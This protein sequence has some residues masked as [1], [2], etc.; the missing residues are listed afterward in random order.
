MS[1]SKIT[2][3]E[4]KQAL[5]DSRFRETLPPD[6]TE[7]VHKFLKNPACACNLPLYRKIMRDCGEQLRSYFPSRELGNIEEEAKNMAENKFSV[8]NC[9]VHELEDKLRKL[10]VGRKQI[11]I[12]RYGDQVTVVVNELDVIY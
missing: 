11:A 1:Q 10:G 2:L 9:S 3:L 5:K 4:I 8:I 6:L 12:S 7:E